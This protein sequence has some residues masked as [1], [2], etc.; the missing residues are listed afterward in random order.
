M[1]GAYTRP[2]VS[3]VFPLLPPSGVVH[4]KKVNII[5]FMFVLV[6]M[7]S[8]NQLTVIVHCGIEMTIN[9]NNLIKVKM[10]LLV[11]SVDVCSP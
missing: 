4:W 7:Q 10:T 6:N 1:I 9:M 11:E 2:A 8:L 3:T 5:M